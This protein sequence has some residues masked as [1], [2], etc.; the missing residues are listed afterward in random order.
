MKGKITFVGSGKVAWHLAKAFDGAGFQIHQIVSRNEESGKALAKIYAA[1]FESNLKNVFADSDFVFLTVPDKSIET[2]AQEISVDGPIFLHCS[3]SSAIE[4][5]S[6]YKTNTGVFYPLQTFTKDRRINYFEIPIFIE[7]SNP[8]TFQKIYELADVI[9]N[10]VKHLDSEKRK[11]LH[12]S[13]VIANN[14][15]NHLLGKAKM[16]MD[17]QNLPM[18]WLKPLVEETVKKA[19]ELGPEN[20]QTGPA[21]RHDESTILKHLEMLDINPELKR[22]YEWMTRDIDKGGR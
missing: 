8:E 17:M 3:G 22:M 18:E 2:V 5:V 1:Y 16:V 6:R 13:A 12:L 20:S 4:S 11:Y 15:T 10:T 21:I 19:F 14:F 9:S 7:A